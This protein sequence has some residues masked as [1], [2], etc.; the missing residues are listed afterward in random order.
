MKHKMIRLWRR[1]CKD[2]RKFIFF[3]MMETKYLF[4]NFKIISNKYAARDLFLKNVLFWS[5][6]EKKEL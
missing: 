4:I 1:K 2:S 6:K 3:N 5:G